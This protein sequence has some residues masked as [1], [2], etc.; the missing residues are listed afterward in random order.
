MLKR[1][2]RVQKYGFGR[3]TAQKA[4][5]ANKKAVAKN[6]QSGIIKLRKVDARD[7]ISSIDTS[8]IQDLKSGF[9]CFQKDDILSTYIKIVE[10]KDGYYDIGLHGTP[11]AVCFGTDE[12]NTSPKLLARIIK[13]RK[14][15]NGENIRLLSCSTGKKIDNEYCFAEELSNALGVK[16]EA[17]N[18]LL[19]ISS[20]GTITVGDDYLGKMVVYSPN[21]RGRVK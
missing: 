2:D 16:V 5:Q 14:D 3:S 12:P 18:D 8:T 13:H 20:K 10:P 15:Y 6:A 4:V 17:P 7:K 21:E 9:S 1:N 11:T 19:Y